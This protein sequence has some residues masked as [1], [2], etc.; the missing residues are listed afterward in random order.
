MALGLRREIG[1]QEGDAE[2]A[3]HRD[4]DD[5]RAP[6]RGRGEDV[7]V[8][9]DDCMAGKQQIVNEADQVSEEHGAK[10]GD[11]AKPKCEQG[12]LHQGQLVALLALNHACRRCL[13]HFNAPLISTVGRYY[14]RARR[15]ASS[16]VQSSW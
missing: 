3:E 8:V 10:A 4:Q 1:H 2:R 15:L 11:D 5:Q 6:R 12:E 13:C 16:Q 7:G 14:A 9:V